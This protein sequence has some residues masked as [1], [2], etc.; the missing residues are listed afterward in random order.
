[1]TQHLIRDDFGN[2]VG[3]REI[4]AIYA[5][6]IKPGDNIIAHGIDWITVIRIERS[7]TEKSI[8]AYYDDTLAYPC[9]ESHIQ[10]KPTSIV[11]RIDKNSFL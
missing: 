6:D 4:T 10:L 3:S 5:T 1:M 9:S 8:Y 11:K 7:N 2:V